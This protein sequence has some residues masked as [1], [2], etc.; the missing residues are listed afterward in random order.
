MEQINFLDD[1]QRD[2]EKEERFQKIK[3]MYEKWLTLPEKTL[4]KEETAEREKL[5]VALWDGYCKLY[6]CALHECEGV[7]NNEYIWMNPCEHEYWVLHNKDTISGEHIEVC[8]YCGV[9]LGKGKGDA[10]LYKADA[11]YWLFYLYWEIPMHDRGFQSPEE[12][13]KIKEVWG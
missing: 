13:Q 10:Y 8:P 1:M 6:G 2:S 5:N 4:I 12:R 11:K 3:Q 9:E 7:P